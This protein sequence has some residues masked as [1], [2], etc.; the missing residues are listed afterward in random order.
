LL[1][2]VNAF[3]FLERSNKNKENR[4][5]SILMV[6]IVLVFYSIINSHFIF[7]YSSIK[8]NDINEIFN[9][10][11]F[12]MNI[13]SF[14]STW[15]IFYVNYWSYIDAI[16][17]SFLPFTLMSIFTIFIIVYSVREA[18]NS[19][20]NMII[21]F[22]S[23]IDSINITTENSTS[24]NINIKKIAL[25]ESINNELILK[26][27]LRNILFLFLTAPIVILKILLYDSFKKSQMS[28]LHENYFDLLKAFAEILQYINHSL[29]F[30][31]YYF[32][33]KTVNKDAHHHF[34]FI[35]RKLF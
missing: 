3:S 20:N 29:N 34:S 32:S 16:I 5:I 21:V 35:Y 15:Y 8:T 22:Q 11:D 19:S 17:Y 7:G 31:F 1:Y 4:K 14:D 30:F 28:H 13:C 18:R 10:S 33:N 24:A 25:W 26:A 23:E 6:L 2:G 9:D 27:V 12:H